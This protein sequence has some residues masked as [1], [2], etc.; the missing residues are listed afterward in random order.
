MATDE[1]A[2]SNECID[3]LIMNVIKSI[4]NMKKSPDCSFIRD[5]ISKLLSNS[6]ITEE[7]VLN[8]LH[9]LANNNEIKNKPKYRRNSYYIIYEIP[10]QVEIPQNP[11]MN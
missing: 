4:R 11:L 1:E 10:V 7:I 5:Y 2:M 3:N 8:R 9:Y 6:D